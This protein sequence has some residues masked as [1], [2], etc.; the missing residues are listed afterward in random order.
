MATP[1]PGTLTFKGLNTGRFYSYTIYMSDVVGASVTFSTTGIATSASQSFINA[2]EDI[3][4]TDV[5]ITTGMGATTAL[6][7]QVGDVPI[8]NVISIANVLNSLAFRAFPQIAISRGK[9][10]TLVQA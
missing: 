1:E 3:V 8:G 9:K 2:Q 6:V 10:F 4:L 7:P 5:S